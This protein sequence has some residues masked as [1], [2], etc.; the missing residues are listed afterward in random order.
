MNQRQLSVLNAMV[1]FMVE[2]V[3]G[4][5]SG[6]ESEVAQIVGSWVLHGT[7]THNYKIIN[8]SHYTSPEEAANDCA[9]RGWRVVGAISSKGTG[10]AHQLILERPVGITHPDD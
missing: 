9:E 6:E 1:T 2:N 8:A 3:P 5:P 4:G 10:Y 7:K